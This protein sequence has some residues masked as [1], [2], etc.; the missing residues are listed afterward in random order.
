MR[1]NSTTGRQYEL[2]A[3]FLLLLAVF[4]AYRPALKGGMLWDDDAHITRPELR[5]L[6]GLARIWTEPGST[7]Q[8]YPLTHT[9]FW[10]QHRL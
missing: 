4:A 7:Q 9:L 6:K 10:V 5:S 3:F 2:A 8:Y 1:N